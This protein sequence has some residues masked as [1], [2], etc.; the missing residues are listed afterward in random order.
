MKLSDKNKSRLYKAASDPI[1]DL[2]I[3]QNGGLSIKEMDNELFLL[4]QKIWRNVKQVL[5]I[6][7]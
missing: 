5:N 3:K 7:D 4:E 1:T 6:K 2:R